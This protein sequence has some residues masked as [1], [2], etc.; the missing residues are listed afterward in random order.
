MIRLASE[1]DAAPIA[2]IYAPCVRSTPISFEVVPPSPAEMAQ[3]IVNTLPRYPWLV[4]ERDGAVAGYAY[5]GPYAQR[6]CYRWSV[7]TTVYVRDDY[8]GQGIGRRLYRA[9]LALLAEQGFRS[10][11]A[12]VTLPNA[13]SVG[14]H[15][16]MGFTPVGVYRDAGHKLGRWHDV[17]WL[18]RALQPDAPRQEDHPAEPVDVTTVL[19]ARAPLWN[20]LDDEAH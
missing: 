20:D 19:A 13:G 16:A 10:A 5:A 8:R 15:E 9:L 12:G 7:T 17:A 3:R 14:L 18:Q 6:V 2:A 4:E 11:Y 1:A